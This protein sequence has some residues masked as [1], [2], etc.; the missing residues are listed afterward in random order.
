MY[1]HTFSSLAWVILLQVSSSLYPLNDIKNSVDIL[2]LSKKI[3]NEK[4]V[5]GEK[6]ALSES[7][8]KRKEGSVKDRICIIYMKYHE[9]NKIIKYVGI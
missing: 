5:L 4:K 9:Y 8:R 2:N 3:K 7:L 6:S 1:S